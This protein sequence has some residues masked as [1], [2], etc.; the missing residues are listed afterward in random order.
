MTQIEPTKFLNVSLNSLVYRDQ[1]RVNGLE[2]LNR[3]FVV[4]EHFHAG[5]C[6][7]VV[8]GLEAQFSDS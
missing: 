6:V 7:R 2:D 5:L 3:T 1:K 8:G 4:A